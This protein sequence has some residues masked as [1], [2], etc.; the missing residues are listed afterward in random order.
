MTQNGHRQQSSERARPAPHS[1]VPRHLASERDHG[2]A[3]RVGRILTRTETG[4]WARCSGHGMTRDGH[5]QE[6]SS[7]ARPVVLPLAQLEL[8]LKRSQTSRSRAKP[9]F[10][11][12]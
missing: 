12:R 6:D 4:C 9:F 11:A 5:P 7:R 1:I 8:R 2:R 3:S 10:A